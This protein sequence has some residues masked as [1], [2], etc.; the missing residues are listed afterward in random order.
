MTVM[1]MD[2]DAQRDINRTSVTDRPPV[3]PGDMKG[4]IH[5]ATAQACADTEAQRKERFPGCDIFQIRWRK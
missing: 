5:I 3:M 4:S 2:Y 1:L